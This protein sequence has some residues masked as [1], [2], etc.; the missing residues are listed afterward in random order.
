MG[1]KIVYKSRDGEVRFERP[2]GPWSR[3]VA[4]FAQEILIDFILRLPTSMTIGRRTI[5]FPR[6]VYAEM[7]WNIVPDGIFWEV[8][9]RHVL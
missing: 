4:K 2:L 7:G 8:N 3:D 6:M 9:A 5:V 1:S